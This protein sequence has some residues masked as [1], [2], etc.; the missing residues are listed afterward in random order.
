MPEKPVREMSRRERERRSLSS[1]V[2][3]STILGS[4]LLGLVAMAIGLGLYTYA[5]I[6]QYVREACLLSR[7]TAMSVT[8]MSIAPIMVD[9]VMNVYRG[10]SE[11]DR[12]RT[13]T[14]EYRRLF[15]LV[16]DSNAYQRLRTSLRAFQNESD[17]NDVYLGVYDRETCALVYVCDP[18]SIGETGYSPGDWEPLERR[19]LEKFLSWDGDGRLY[20]I[21]NT[22]K[23]GWL[24]TAGTP[25]KDDAGET[26][27]F[28]LVDVTLR[29]VAA[30][31]GSFALQYVLT[32]SVLTLLYAA[33]LTRR[34][35]KTV[36]APINDM[37]EAARLYV[38]DRR[39]GRRAADHFSR[40]NIRTGDEVENLGL[41]MADMERG[42]AE[43]EEDLL[44]ATAEKERIGTELSLARRIQAEMLPGTF[45]PFPD[46]TDFDVYASMKPAREVGGDFY[47][48]FLLDEDRLGLVMA[49]VS[50]KGVPAALFMMIC[51]ILTQNYAV[52]GENPGRVLETL[53]EQICSNNKEEMFITVWLG[54]LD[55]KTGRL[56]AANA[57]H[58][59]PALKTPEGHFELLKDKHGFIVGGMEGMH[60]QEYELT[61]APGARLFLYTDG[62]PE[63]TAEGGEL[64]GTGRM[65]E[66]LGRAEDASPREILRS[67][68][69]A[70]SR[71]VGK[72]P[73][74]D[75]L[76]MMCVYYAGQTPEEGPPMK[77]LTLEAKTENIQQITDFVNAEL[78]A[79]DCPMKAQMQIDMAIDEVFANIASYSYGEDVGEATVRLELEEDPRAVVLTFIDRGM[80]FDPLAKEDPDVSLSLEDRP[81]GGLGIFL[82]KN[83]M[84]DVT[85]E[86]RD[87]QNVLR[88]KKRI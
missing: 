71:F 30:G 43:Y 1:R 46:R 59:Y 33:L 17:T 26:V 69:E 65:L 21:S 45:P 74:Y 67:V 18:D 6:G 3:R 36:V 22:E 82:V 42:L 75:D 14:E 56:T 34:M 12:A 68:D 58:E 32:I 38:R 64:F 29:D 62:V 72:A 39:S 28:L 5:L 55:L 40:L 87:G 11:E 19:E 10:L 13:G 83:I 51:K 53:N 61:L 52:M 4:I 76:T 15:Y 41:V 23:F 86:Y 63:A 70:V 16:R 57:G 79:A 48:F 25:L 78:E 8:R 77:E 9:R 31:M 2:F 60:Y 66:A 54:I 44:K 24:C 73:Q 27:A 20:D 50:G 85:Y 81:V 80:P 84:D 35:R 88:I 7:T 47:D 49:D 37:A